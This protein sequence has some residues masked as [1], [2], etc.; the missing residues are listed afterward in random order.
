MTRF[1]L[2]THM[3]DWL[4]KTD[5][6]LMV[7]FHRLG[8]VKKH[9]G[10]AMA[11]YA[12]D[13][14]AYTVLEKYGAWPI[15]ALS[16]ADGVR[17]FADGAGLPAWCAVQ[18]WVCSP[19][20]RAK[21]GLSVREHQRLTTSSL[22]ELR[23]MAPEV[24]WLPVLQGWHFDHYL[25]HV[26]VYRENGV[27][28]EQEPLVGVG[29]LA[30]RQDTEEAADIIACL[31]GLGLSLHAFGYKLSGLAASAPHLASA[32]SMAWSYQARNSP[33]LAG[34]K[35]ANCAHCL[36]YAAAWY[37]RVRDLISRSTARGRQGLLFAEKGDGLQTALGRPGGGQSPDGKAP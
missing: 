13:S 18:D 34:H 22:L 19:E 28:L 37:W 10:K 14:G 2:G 3:T 25:R 9:R 33:P 21:T 26:E 27:R 5:I 20:V 16:Y 8:R 1:W 31:S 7:S 30:M 32:D 15:P 11:H 17:K 6:D 35:H 4:W 36:D 23:D 29:S 12:L 24:H